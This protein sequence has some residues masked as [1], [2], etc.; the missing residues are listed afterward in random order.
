MKGHESAH[1][2]LGS[3]SDRRMQQVMEDVKRDGYYEVEGLR[4]VI[5]EGREGKFKTYR[6]VS[7]TEK[8]KFVAYTRHPLT[9]ERITT[10]ELA[11]L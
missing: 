6:V 7:T 10:E 11:A 8:P 4:Y 1:G 5:E 3:E 2:F 9:G